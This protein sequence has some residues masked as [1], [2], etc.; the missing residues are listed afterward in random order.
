MM[1]DVAAGQISGLI[2]DTITRLSRT[3]QELQKVID[4]FSI[5]DA[6]IVCL[7]EE[8]DTS[9][10]AGKLLVAMIADMANQEKEQRRTRSQVS[11]RFPFV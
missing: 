1:A 3:T 6:S 5:V 7:S 11:K 9:T 10:P 8:L 4:A 2:V